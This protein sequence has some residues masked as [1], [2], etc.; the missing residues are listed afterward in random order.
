MAQNLITPAGF[1]PGIAY[2]SQPDP[3]DP[4]TVHIFQVLNASGDDID[5]EATAALYDAWLKANAGTTG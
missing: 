5:A 1:Q 3:A 2:V 4:N